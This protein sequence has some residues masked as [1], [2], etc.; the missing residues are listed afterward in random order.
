MDVRID[1]DNLP[2]FSQDLCAFRIVI[3]TPARQH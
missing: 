3:G 1:T 2:H